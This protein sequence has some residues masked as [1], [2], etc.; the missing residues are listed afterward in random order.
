MSTEATCGALVDPLFVAVTVTLTLPPVGLPGARK[1][2][3]LPTTVKVMP[4]ELNE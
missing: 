1:V 3:V 4:G 2:A